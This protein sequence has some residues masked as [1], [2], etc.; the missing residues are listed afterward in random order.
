MHN[1]ELIERYN[2]ERQTIKERI[3]ELNHWLLT[4]TGTF[5]SF[6]RFIFQTIVIKTFETRMNKSYNFVNFM[7]NYVHVD[8]HSIL[9]SIQLSISNNY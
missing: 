7:L 2:H 4:Y 8:I 6:R 9:I 3:D 5:T 1:F